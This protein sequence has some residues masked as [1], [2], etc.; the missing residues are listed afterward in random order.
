MTS[1]TLLNH[2]LLSVL[3]NRILILLEEDN[4]PNLSIKY[5]QI[6]AIKK[7]KMTSKFC[8]GIIRSFYISSQ[9]AGVDIIFV[10]V[11]LLYQYELI[12]I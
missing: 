6:I 12:L 9:K 7:I 5:Q 8:N 2:C 11:N 4:K 10:M 1:L 3:L